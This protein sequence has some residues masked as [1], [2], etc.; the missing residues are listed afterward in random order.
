MVIGHIKKFLERH[1]K[2]LQ[3]KRKDKDR[4]ESFRETEEM[5]KDRD[6][7]A[8]ESNRNTKM[9]TIALLS[10]AALVPG[11]KDL[12]NEVK[13]EVDEAEAARRRP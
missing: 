10:I 9:M 6:E 11:A 4:A 12:L 7:A 8:R 3:E 1:G 13:A 2:R 5:K